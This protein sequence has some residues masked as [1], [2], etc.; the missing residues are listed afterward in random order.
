LSNYNITYYSGILT[1]DKVGLTITANNQT[2]QYGTTF[3]FTGNEFTTAG[4]VNGDHVG[5]VTIN[6]TGATATT[7]VAG[8]PY[9]IDISNATGS[10]MSNYNITYVGGH[11]NVTKADL[12]ISGLD[13]TKPFTQ[14]QILSGTDFIVSGLRNADAVTQVS[15]SSVGAINS[16]NYGVYS[17][18]VSNAAGTGLANYNITYHNGS[19]TIPT[20]D[21]GDDTG[22]DLPKT[23]QITSQEP[24]AVNSATNKATSMVVVSNNSPSL[25]NLDV[26]QIEEN[27][28]SKSVTVMGNLVEIDPVLLKEINYNPFARN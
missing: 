24:D 4:L 26:K 16:A 12:S 10:A 5:G 19:I 28:L 9:N 8:G 6:S 22:R 11:M 17:V 15:L 1:V 23:V 18:L 2:K 3:N 13:Y 20:I 25:A 14:T 27:E 21:S 7:N